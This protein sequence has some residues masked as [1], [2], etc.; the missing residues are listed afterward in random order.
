MSWIVVVGAVAAVCSV[1]RH[2]PNEWINS[3]KSFIMCKQDG[4][5][6]VCF[7]LVTTWISLCKYSTK[8][9]AHTFQVR[10][11][12]LA[13]KSAVVFFCISI[14]YMHWLDTSSQC[15]AKQL[16]KIQV[17][18]TLHFTSFAPN[19]VEIEKAFAFTDN[20]ACCLSKCTFEHLIQININMKFD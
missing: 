8:S 11:F 2:L 5:F 13:Q 10:F 19:P 6:L 7:C 18:F 14:R 20:G 9:C 1:Y 16:A 4:V 17:F 15:R 12:N 3:I